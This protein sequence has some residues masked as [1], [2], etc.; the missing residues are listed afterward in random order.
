[1]K[2]LIIT[3]SIK[4]AKSVKNAI[5]S[6]YTVDVCESLDEAIYNVKLVEYVAII[7]DC[8]YAD[9][10]KEA[11]ATE[12]L[13]AHGITIA[14]LAILPAE[15]VEARITLLEAG[16]DYFIMRPL[17]LQELRARLGA[18]KRR[19][20]G[21]FNAD[22]KLSYKHLTADLNAR[23]AY[24]KGD[25]I[26]LTRKEYD[27]LIYLMK[28]I[29]V[30]VTRKMILS[31]VWELGGGGEHNTIDVHVKSLRDKIDKP[32][33]TSYIKTAYGVGYRLG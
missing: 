32:Y 15:Q 5:S 26:Q 28:N 29:G 30:S 11:A 25:C 14:I 31:N 33:G 12:Y 8:Y 19:D 16:V 3:D 6:M 18:L 2:L 17:Y 23:V 24:V 20:H 10:Y 9:E 7:M 4:R 22:Y 21:H 1:M 27:I 13:R